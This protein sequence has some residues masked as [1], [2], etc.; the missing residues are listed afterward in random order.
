MVK[1]KCIFDD[2]WQTMCDFFS[3]RRRNIIKKGYTRFKEKIPKIKK[4]NTSEPQLSPISKKKNKGPNKDFLDD[5][6]SCFENNPNKEEPLML[7]E[8][9]GGM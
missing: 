1:F 4:E 3:C 8:Q 9:P 6:Q 7:S 5:M 2:C